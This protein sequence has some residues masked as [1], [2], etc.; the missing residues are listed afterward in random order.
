MPARVILAHCADDPRADRLTCSCEYQEVSK[1]PS[2]HF[3]IVPTPLSAFYTRG[4]NNVDKLNHL[5]LLSFCP[6]CRQVFFERI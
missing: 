6:H 1:C 5:N 3:A 2:C 4:E